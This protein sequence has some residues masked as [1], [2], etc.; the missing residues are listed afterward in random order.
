MKKNKVKSKKSK[1]K[2]RIRGFIWVYV[3]GTMIVVGGVMGY[4]LIGAAIFDFDDR[5]SLTMLAM[6]PI[7]AFV[8][9]L[10]MR[11]VLRRIK[12][13]MEKLAVA[14]DEVAS[15]N[16]SY[17]IDMKDAG[18]YEVLYKQFNAMALE[19]KKTREEMESFTNEFAHEFKTP[20]TA[21]SGF[22]DLLL[23][24][25]EFVTEEEKKEYL[26]MI[27]DESKRLLKLSQNA[28]LLSKV[29]AMQIVSGQEHYDLAEQIR[30]CIILLSQSIE[31][32]NIEIDM[33]EDLMLPFYGNQEI[34]QHVWINLLNNAVKFTPENG[35]ITVAGQVIE[36]KAFG[37]AASEPKKFVEIRISDSGIGMD[38]ETMAKIFDKYYQ[39]DSVSLTKGS[40]IGLS[41]VKRVVTVCEGEIS[42]SSWPG[43]GS[44][45]TVTLPV[46]E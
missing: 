27:S 6:V 13:R 5:S 22:S 36:N 23:H 9:S 29:E 31:E 10:G 2:I 45:F 12:N 41:I 15:G 46:K 39:N 1:E 21:I 8:Y 3:I 28:L 16:L 26:Q 7:M 11:P 14:M 20:I 38:E 40:G 33:D 30:R 25:D 32:K 4:G 42:V 43:T 44:T 24:E 34:L 17:Q 37:N 18:E 35:K 19:L